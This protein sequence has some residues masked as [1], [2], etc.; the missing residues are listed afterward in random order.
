[1]SGRVEYPWKSYTAALRRD[2]PHECRD[3]SPEVKS[4]ENRAFER[5]TWLH[6]DFC[7]VLVTGFRALQLV[8]F[9][10]STWIFGSL[11]VRAAFLFLNLISG[12]P[13][14]AVSLSRR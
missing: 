1:M 10:Q 6:I 7:G 12:I 4:A 11:V 9:R 8:L 2:G 14:A 5:I 3:Q 13:A